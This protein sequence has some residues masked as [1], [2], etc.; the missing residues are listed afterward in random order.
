MT[1][2]TTCPAPSSTTATGTTT[3]R[4]AGTYQVLR[5]TID[6][7]FDYADTEVRSVHKSLADANDAARKDLLT[8]YSVG[9]LDEYE[10]VI[11]S[12]GGVRISTRFPPPPPPP[13]PP[14]TI[15][16]PL[17]QSNGRTIVPQKWT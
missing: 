8:E 5:E 9:E 3:E 16:S 7:L 14:R 10:E 1:I 11:G 15:L 17:C 6:I 13:P 4:S 12:D 2:T